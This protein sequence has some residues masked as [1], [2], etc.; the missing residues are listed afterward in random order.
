MC[1]S[2]NVNFNES[3]VLNNW[4]M[5]LYKLGARMCIQPYKL[6]YYHMKNLSETE[7][8]SFIHL[9]ILLFPRATFIDFI[10]IFLLLHSYVFAAY[11]QTSIQGPKG[12]L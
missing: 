2:L 8:T 9:C 4:D 1:V 12:N 6:H 11:I 5:F 3:L 10:S 7:T